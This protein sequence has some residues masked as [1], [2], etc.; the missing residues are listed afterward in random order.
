M[1]GL[2]QIDAERFN[3]ASPQFD[4]TAVANTDDA[5]GRTAICDA[6]RLPQGGSLEVNGAS[7]GEITHPGQ[8]SQER[9]P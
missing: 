7:R 6:W 2:P 3:R 5:R 9:C 1:A 8:A 4:P